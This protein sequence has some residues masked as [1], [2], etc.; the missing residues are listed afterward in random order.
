MEPA[1][2]AVGNVPAGAR[3]SAMIAACQLRDAGAGCGMRIAFRD[4]NRARPSSGSSAIPYGIIGDVGAQF[5]F[6]YDL[7]PNE[8]VT[9]YFDMR[10]RV[11]M[12][13]ITYDTRPYS[14]RT[15]ADYGR[16]VFTY[17]PDLTSPAYQPYVTEQTNVTATADGLIPTDPSIPA[18]IVFPVK[19]T[20]GI[21]GAQIKA[22]FKTGG[23]V[24]IGRQSDYLNTTYSP[25]VTWAL[26]SEQQQE[27]YFPFLPSTIQ[28]AM[29]Y[30]VKFEFQGAGAGLKGVE[31]DTEV[32]MS[33]WSMPGLE[34]GNNHI[35]FEAGALQNGSLKVTY[36]YDDQA[37][38]HFY[39]PAT[40]NYG[41]H[42]WFRAGGVLTDTGQKQE[43]F[44]KLTEAPFGTERVTLA[45]TQVSGPNAG[46]KV[47]TLIVNQSMPFGYYKV[48][49]DGRDDAGNVLPP[50]MYAYKLT[51]NDAPTQ[52]ARLYLFPAI[53]PVPNEIRYP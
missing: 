3:E 25:S 15:Y 48:Y 1:L 31:I 17:T 23:N 10:G 9:T 45:I 37:N 8:R 14:Y 20:W 24:Y 12:T 18:S 19:S 13:S 6:N 11:D 52:G 2:A 44:K 33:P 39:A 42:I 7:R 51:E 34:Y 28:G 46:I 38:H 29:A 41:R 5:D 49:W 27:R 47:R 16:A 50:G 21:A 35:H 43:Y 30:W 53:W 26:L 32:T 4:S 40:S 36:V 22:L